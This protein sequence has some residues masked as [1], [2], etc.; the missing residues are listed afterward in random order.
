MNKHR[1][2][3]PGVGPVRH[4][5]HPSAD[6]DALPPHAELEEKAVLG[7]VLL[8][9]SQKSQS[10]VDALLA[11]LKPSL[12]YM[13]RHQDALAAFRDIR[14]K[15]HALDVITAH[16]ISGLDMVWMSEAMDECPS[17]ASFDYYLPHLEELSHRRWLLKKGAELRE[18]AQ[19]AEVSL[20]DTRARLVELTEATDKAAGGASP[21]ETLTIDD[22]NE[23]V[24]DPA[25][26]LIGENVIS[27]QSKTVICG[28]PGLGKS[29]LT[30]TLALAGARG[31]GDWMGYTV[32]RRWRTYVLQS[33]NSQ[34]R[35]KSEVEGFPADVIRDYVRWSKPCTL[36]FHKQDFRR[37]LSQIWHEWPF[38]MLVIDPWTDV[39]RDAEAGDVA[40][41]FANIDASLPRGERQPAVVVVAHIRKQGRSD[42]WRPKA[43]SELMHEILGSQGT[44]GKARTVF[45]LQPA[46]PTDNQSDVVILDVGKCNDGRANPPSAWIR[47]NGAFGPVPGFDFD[48]WRNPPDE[49]DRKVITEQTLR[50]VLEETYLSRKDAVAAIVRQGFSEPAAYRALSADGKWASLIHTAKDGRLVIHKA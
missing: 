10:E 14:S 2:S 40:E 18:L 7:C 44:A 47:K 30:T 37:R 23:Y 31:S 11:R 46:D 6:P 20:E 16:S 3:R 50:N 33:E 28:W 49:G 45:A 34:G 17:I 43:G 48:A 38:D 4:V 35:L 41:A 8:A 5:F 12:F 22:L 27:R 19:S 9:G 24:P 1:D 36:A 29:R 15:G 32:R 25:T 26:F 21:I 42:K 13:L 39:V